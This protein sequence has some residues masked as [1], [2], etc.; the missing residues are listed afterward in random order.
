MQQIVQSV[1][2]GKLDLLNVP[3]PLVKPGHLLIA[4]RYSVISAGTEKMLRDL[5]KKSLLQKAKERPDHVKR[6]IEKIR[7][8]G[9][10]ET[11]QQVNQKLDEP[12]PLGYSSAGT[13]LACGRGVQDFKTGDLV[14][15]NGPHAE[16]V[17]VPR[18]LCVKLNDESEL[19]Q[20]SMAVIAAI[21]LQGI[22]LSRVVLGETAL[23]IGLGL[24]G[25]ITVALLKAAGIRVLAT[26]VNNSRC[27]LAKASMG[28]DFACS[29]LQPQSVFDHTNGL[30]ADVVIITAATKSN[31]PVSLAAETVRQKGRIIAV[32]AVGMDLPRRPLYF[33]EAEFVISCSYG[34]GRYDHKYEE[35][36]IDYPAA[37]VRWSENRNMQCIINLL[38]EKKLNLAPLITHRMQLHEFQDAYNLIESGTDNFLAILLEYPNSD[39][40]K[41]LSLPSKKA[42]TPS[43][44][45]T[46]RMIGIGC[47]GAGNFATSTLL[48]KLTSI[49]RVVP[50]A[51]CSS[52]G[53]RAAN[54]AKQF[55][56]SQAVADEVEL[57]ANELIDAVF[58]LTQH[59]QHAQQFINAYQ[60]NKHVYV[61]KPLCIDLQQLHEIAKL[62]YEDNP[63][64]KTFMVGFNRRFAPLS[65]QLKE[66]FADCTEPLTV[67][68]R[69]NAGRVPDEHW[70]QNDDIGGGRIIGEA[71]H[72][73]DLATFLTSSLPKRIYSESICQNAAS[74]IT[75][76]AV[77]IT[78]RHEN[79]SIS[80]IS[81]QRGGDKAFP[82]ERVEV[83]G[84]GKVGVLDDFKALQLCS[85]GKIK[86][87]K[88]PLDKGHTECLKRFIHSIEKGLP[89]PIEPAEILNVTLAS[90]LAVQSLREGGPI[91]L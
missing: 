38:T 18:N 39:H 12:M 51:I 4:N 69:F 32:G 36:G 10:Q 30:G 33:K 49:S 1:R 91:D 22:R 61:E 6:I 17:T 28:A 43:T 21:A 66:Y 37:H 9:I 8:E 63:T 82:K 74:K 72:G 5:A 14:A 2:S 56:F 76:D 60:A 77:F 20:S 15:S 31:Q 64:S 44:Q 80:C 59:N 26:D 89:S 35:E 53:L 78:I 48:P 85:N 67:S 52:G 16:I 40:K 71:C 75:D 88:K 34:P 50:V 3:T 25:Q 46:A 7:V 65:I 84:G 13:V 45:P 41:K 70:V 29:K 55:G 83:I 68:I 11:L 19:E 54:T 62:I 57:L 58:I 27:N 42:V 47:I 90:I 23:V 79:G 87:W 81:Y 24:V 73:I 86:K